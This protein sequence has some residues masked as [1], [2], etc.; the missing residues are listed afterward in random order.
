[1]RLIQHADG[2]YADGVLLIAGGLTIY[3]D[4]LL[5]NADVR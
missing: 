4:G 5:M 3:A 2:T 1:M